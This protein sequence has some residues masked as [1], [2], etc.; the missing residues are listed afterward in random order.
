[1]GLMSTRLIFPRLYFPKIQIKYTRKSAE[2][3]KLHIKYITGDYLLLDTENEFDL[4]LISHN[5]LEEI[6]NAHNFHTT[7][8]YD[9]IL[10][11]CDIDN[12]ED[13][14]FCVATK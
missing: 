8:Y 10:N 9:N 2:R 3:K 11:D 12:P 5:D 4:I 13:V 1:M 14:T 7:E 6:L